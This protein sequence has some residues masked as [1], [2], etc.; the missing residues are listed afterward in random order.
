MTRV[1]AVVGL[2]LLL[3]CGEQQVMNRNWMN[4]RDSTG[5]AELIVRSPCQ[6]CLTEEPVAV[7]GSSDGLGFVEETDWGLEDHLGRYWLNQDEILKVFNP[8]GSY[9]GT[10]GRSGGGPLEFQFPLPAG[11][12]SRRNVQ[13]ADPGNARESRV[14]D[15]LLLMEEF[16]FL[17]GD[18]HSVTSFPKSNRLFVSSTKFADSTMKLMHVVED[19]R[20]LVSF[21]EPAR[22]SAPAFSNHRRTAVSASGDVLF[23][24][25]EYEYEI[26][27]W[28]ADGERIGGFVGPEMNRLPVQP[29]FFDFDDNPI[30]SRIRAIQ[31]IDR[32]RLL[33]IRWEVGPGWKERYE[34]R[35]YSPGMTGIVLKDGQT[36]DSVY[37][38]IVDVVDIPSRSI[39]AQQV[40]SGLLRTFVG[41]GRALQNTYDL[42]PQVVIWNLQYRPPGFQADGN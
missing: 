28:T 3:G 10:V 37:T 23:S 26:E 35:H 41:S 33:V 14:S 16:P 25:K 24:A 8:D 7:L 29:T 17:S 42:V 12:D 22:G 1:V 21:G 18:I 4:A 11:V 36:A 19:G 5:F 39:V 6:D 30:P 9:L 13:V 27:M 20:V 15:V 40:T 32:D 34:E 38:S 2:G 31:A